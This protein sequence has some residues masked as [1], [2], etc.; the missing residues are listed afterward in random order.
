[1]VVEIVVRRDDGTVERWEGPVANRVWSALDFSWLDP[2]EKPIV[3]KPSGGPQPPA[4]SEDMYERELVSAGFKRVEEN[5]VVFYEKPVPTRDELL[6]DLAFSEAR[7]EAAYRTGSDC[8]TAAQAKKMAATMWGAAEAERLFPGKQ[9]G[10][11]T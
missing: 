11:Y 1:M 7:S 3:T 9:Y 2:S 8:A 5:G 4:K 10:D 6:H